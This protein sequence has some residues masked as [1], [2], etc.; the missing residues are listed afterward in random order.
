MGTSREILDFFKLFSIILALPLML[1]VKFLYFRFCHNKEQQYNCPMNVYK[2]FHKFC[3]INFEN[4]VHFSPFRMILVWPKYC[5]SGQIRYVMKLCSRHPQNM[6][7]SGLCN[8]MKLL[9]THLPYNN[10]SK[11]R[12]TQKDAW[13]KEAGRLLYKYI[14]LSFYCKVCVWVVQ[15]L[16]VR[17]C[18]RPNINFIFWPHCYDRHV[19]SFLFS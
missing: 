2:S 13:R 5:K 19:V 9:Y 8:E 7:S 14:H 11:D 15:S 18:W 17:G 16:H 1:L 12:R 6:S 3:G 10:N 4:I